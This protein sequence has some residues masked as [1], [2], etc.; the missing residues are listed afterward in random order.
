MKKIL[1]ISLLMMFAACSEPML[2]SEEEPMLMNA[3]AVTPTGFGSDTPVFLFWLASDFPNIGVEAEGDFPQPYFTAWP[4]QGID[5]YS[6]VTYNTGK[7]YP[8][9]DQEVYCTGFFPA[10]L[11]VDQDR[12]KK[13]WTSLTVPA[14]NIG[15]TDVMVPADHITGKS[16]AHFEKKNPKEPL[17]F[18]H[19]QSKITFK[20]KMG[21]E[22][23]KNRYLRNIR[24]TVPGTELMSSLKWEGGRYVAD[25]KSDDSFEVV[26]ND[27]DP[28]QLDPNQLARE[29]GVVYIYPGKT[30]LKMKVEVEMSDSPLFAESEIISAESEVAFT[31]GALLENDAYE[32]V[33]MINYDSIVLQGRK[34]EWEDGGK[35]VLP[36][37][38]DKD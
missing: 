6:S 3:R 8:E 2:T 22:M 13:S 15:L 19:A 18:I 31:V 35:I 37:Y 14:Q 27:P 1:F 30:S 32:I 4:Y 17:K 34:A 24:V 33:L 38:P 25:G 20:A 11:T 26:L 12:E 28:N 7:K 10:T 21:S 9:N 29:I 5:A 16:T 36:I 23:A